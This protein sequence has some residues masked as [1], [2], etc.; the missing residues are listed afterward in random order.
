[1]LLQVISITIFI[2]QIKFNN[3]ISRIITFI[4]P[5]TFD[6][7]LIHENPYIRSHY[8]RTSFN[9]KRKNNLN[10]FHT[11]LSIIKRGF[12]IFNICIFFAYI[13]NIIF[14][15]VKIKNLCIKFEYIVTKLMNYLI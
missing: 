9:I 10:L 6:I 2:S 3:Y 15:I 5:L 13:R 4:G 7:Y 8:I 1:M 12:F 11:Y 14:R